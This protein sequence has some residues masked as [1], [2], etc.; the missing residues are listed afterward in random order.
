MTVKNYDYNYYLKALRELNEAT[1][2]IQPKSKNTK[3]YKELNYI[4]NHITRHYNDDGY[5]AYADFETSQGIQY[6][7][8]C[9]GEIEE[10]RDGITRQLDLQ[11]MKVNDD[12]SNY[13]AFDVRSTVC[14]TDKSGKQKIFF[15]ILMM[16][17][18]YEEFLEAY[19]SRKNLV[20]N[21]IMISD[22]PEHR[23]NYFDAI[24]NLEVVTQKSNII[25]G[26]FVRKYGL[27][28]TPLEAEDTIIL[29][30][31]LVS[32]KNM[33]DEKKERVERENRKK[34]QLY[35]ANLNQAKIKGV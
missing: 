30:K 25:H 10:H 16:V 22:T 24:N 23:E 21:H 17:A 18:A 32:T 12:R 29:K 5:F 11:T 8:F 15:H 31:Y 4:N 26:K 27:Y 19:M 20:V 3:V 35:I 34:V 28:N 13:R 7:I 1:S 6:T 33:R 14:E 2:T 9:N